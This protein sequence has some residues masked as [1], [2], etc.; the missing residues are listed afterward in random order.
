MRNRDTLTILAEQVGI[1]LLHRHESV[2]CAESCTGGWL[3]KVITD[4]PGSSQWFECGFVTYSNGAKKNLLDV[5]ETTL[6]KYGAVSEPTVR[7]MAL[8][9][10]QRSASQ[11]AV[12]ISGIA[13]PDGGSA[14]KPI[15]TVW[16]SWAH[17]PTQAAVPIVCCQVHRFTGDRESVRYL[18]VEAALQGLLDFIKTS[19][20]SFAP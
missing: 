13:G 8:G 9:A 11:V 19:H 12:A 1:A 6:Q 16:I 17:R 7:E 4:T 20:H 10:L 15:G 2:T 18:A 5:Q 3:C 14:T